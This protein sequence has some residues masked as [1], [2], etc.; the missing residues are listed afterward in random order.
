[1][2]KKVVA[3]Q[4]L[5][6]LERNS[7]FEMLQSG[8]RAHHITET[9]LVIVTKRLIASDHVLLS[10]LVLLG[11]SA[12]FDTVHHS[13]QLNRLECVIGIVGTVQYWFRSYLS[14]SYQF[15]H[16]VSYVVSYDTI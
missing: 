2:Y 9:A 7:L 1:M 10:I 8:F 15:A 14:D 13:I 6:H 12:A 3:T 5:D 16:V 11:F 4:L